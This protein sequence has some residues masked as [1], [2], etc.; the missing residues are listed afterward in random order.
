MKILICA[1]WIKI[2]LAVFYRYMCSIFE[3]MPFMNFHPYNI[4][5]VH[6]Q[7]I[8]VFICRPA[9]WFMYI[10]TG[11]VSANDATT[12]V[13]IAFLDFKYV[14]ALLLVV[15]LFGYHFVSNNFSLGCFWP[16]IFQ[17]SCS[18]I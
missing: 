15:F 10:H 5:Y 4:Q 8:S 11:I 9:A 14:C 18:S 3:M 13:P 1:Q 12:S 7:L 17:S 16:E 6:R 2:F